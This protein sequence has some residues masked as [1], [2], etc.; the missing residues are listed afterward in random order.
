MER[1]YRRLS[2]SALI[3]IYFLIRPFNILNRRKT[4]KV[5]RCAGIRINN[6]YNVASICRPERIVT[7]FAS[8]LNHTK[9]INQKN[10]MKNNGT[11]IP[12]MSTCLI[13]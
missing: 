10:K 3:N 1:R 12:M 9:L 4:S 7:S 11:K 5:I 6:K 2:R 8:P 13:E